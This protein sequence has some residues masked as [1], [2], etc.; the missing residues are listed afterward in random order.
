MSPS[1]VSGWNRILTLL[2]A[3]GCLAC[4]T[5][6]SRKPV[7]ATTNVPPQVFGSRLDFKTPPGPKDGYSVVSCSNADCVG[8][9]GAGRHAFEPQLRLRDELRGSLRDFASIHSSGYGR[10][11]DSG[12]VYLD[13]FDWREVDRVVAR[14]GA[15]LRQHDLSDA[16]AV[17]VLPRR[18]DVPLG[19]N[20]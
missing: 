16:V 11:C 12:G 6:A 14:I 5:G 17:C 7:S 8:V 10:K 15:F 13:M 3:S 20:S 19:G 1:K 18:V 9:T 2:I 4:A